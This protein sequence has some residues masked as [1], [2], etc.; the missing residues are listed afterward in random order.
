MG[1]AVGK[2]D[3]L[4]A[5]AQHLLHLGLGRSRVLCCISGNP[6]PHRFRKLGF[7]LLGKVRKFAAKCL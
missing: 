6:G 1:E 4:L 3:D 7:D 2:A 5:G